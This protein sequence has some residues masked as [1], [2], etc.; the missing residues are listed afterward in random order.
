MQ[1]K[2]GTCH[3]SL[4]YSTYRQRREFQC[5]KCIKSFDRAEYLRNHVSSAH[6]NE[7]ECKE[8]SLKFASVK[9]WKYHNLK[10]QPKK[11]FPCTKCERSYNQSKSLQKHYERHLDPNFRP[12]YVRESVKKE[13][14]CERCEKQDRRKAF[15]TQEE[16]D[17][18]IQW[19][20]V[21]V[22]N[23]QCSICDK[24]F[25][26]KADMNLHVGLV[27]EGKKRKTCTECAKMYFES[28][29]DEHMLTVHGKRKVV[30]WPKSEN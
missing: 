15:D 1:T 13:F 6:R 17:Y 4:T 25:R 8:C 21:K 3:H 12:D 27:H 19:V 10:H 24:K 7:Y 11:A 9:R 29:L 28:D 14:S 22:Q 16:L 5:E 23:Y 2:W 26:L 20:H 18:H 30:D